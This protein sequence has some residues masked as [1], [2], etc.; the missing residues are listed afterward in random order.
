MLRMR[1]FNLPGMLFIPLLIL[2]FI[3]LGCSTATGVA[4]SIQEG[5]VERIVDADS[6]RWLFGY[7]MMDVNDDHT[8]IEATPVR[9]IQTHFN[10]RTFLE[11]SPC[12]Y[13]LSIGAIH[14]GPG[15]LDV[16]ITLKHPFPGNSYLTWFDVR[17]IAI[18]PGSKNFPASGLVMNDATLGD[19]EVMNPDGYTRLFNEVEYAA[20]TKPNQLFEYS[21][22][23]YTT[24][25]PFN[26]T[27]NAFKYFY[28]DFQNRNYFATTDVVTVKYKIELPDGPLTFSYAVDA[29]WM[30]PSKNLPTVPDDFP[31]YANC[32]EAYAL[33]AEYA[34]ND[35]ILTNCVG[36]SENLEVYVFDHQ[37]EG[38]FG[39]TV[40]FECPELFDGFV[41]G[42]FINQVGD[43]YVYRGEL[44]YQKESTPPGLYRVLIE[45]T[46]KK[47]SPVVHH[48]AYQIVYI[49][50]IEEIPPVAKAEY[51]GP[52]PLTVGAQAE[53]LSLY[54]DSNGWDDVV[55]A[56]WD[57]DGDGVYEETG[58]VLLAYH[59]YDSPGIYAV[60][61]KVTDV[62]DE[63]D[64]LDEPLMVEVVK[65][66]VE[67]T[68]PEDTDYKKIGRTYTYASDEMLFNTLPVDITDTD[69]PWDFTTFPLPNQFN[70]RKTLA[71]DDPEVSGVA[72]WFNP[73]SEYFLKIWGSI[74]DIKDGMFYQ[75]EEHNVVQDVLKMWG[76]YEPLD[77]GPVAF[78]SPVVIPFPININTSV[79]K[80]I[81]LPGV[82]T[83]TYD[84]KALGE[85]EITVPY[86]GG[87][88]YDALMMRVFIKI[89]TK[90]DFNASGLI[91]EFLED[92][93]KSVAMVAAINRPGSGEFHFDES[94]LMF[95]DTGI[96]SVN[97]LCKIEDG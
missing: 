74:Y 33:S 47:S 65:G 72:I 87:T 38:P 92:D 52:T 40:R 85:G 89:E 54:Y 88:V 48:I 63:E 69:G 1:Q 46:D 66:G 13:C 82:A 4:P 53:F 34:G 96:V 42:E 93:G 7:W 12:Q 11:D 9:T 77:L 76:V 16:N 84:Y 20:G 14:P 18:F 97:A 78:P 79:H 80:D 8:G 67:I 15:T 58:Y 51:I 50:V 27:V 49:V 32:V 37:N 22:G 95:Y 86:N 26:S 28:T 17:G 41:N 57:F 62:C 45:V 68:L 43:T 70:K 56:E 64:I 83:F 61:H 21:P 6:S 25:G 35:D 94:T 2:L 71:K 19:A 44:I 31:P 55:K 39:Q 24:G 23:K 3:L 36:A 10:V 90:G 73:D 29:S 91:Y 30:A 60:Q 5:S 59:T 81:G 75:V